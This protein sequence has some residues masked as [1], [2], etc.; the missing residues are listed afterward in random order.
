MSYED[1]KS[2]KML[3]THCFACRRPLRDSMSVE[4]GMGPVC[5]G[6]AGYDEVGC[7]LEQRQRA[8]ALIHKVA[9]NQTDKAVIKQCCV[10]LMALKFR[11]VA[12]VVAS[13]LG[14]TVKDG[15]EGRFTLRV[16][17]TWDWVRESGS[18]PGKH[19]NRKTKAETYPN[20]QKGRV[21]AALVKHFPGVVGMGPKGFFVVGGTLGKK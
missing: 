1:A 17:F 10:E 6:K 7:T 11:G 9:L 2:T 3:A 19:Y 12:E 18:I 14:V 4:I 16:P 5:R 21:Y 20:E 8:N 13:R 15:P